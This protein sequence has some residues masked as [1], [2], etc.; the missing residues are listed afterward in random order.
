MPIDTRYR[1]YPATE[2]SA[3]K[4]S[5][6]QQLKQIEGAGQSHSINGR[7][8]AAA[9]FDRLHDGLANINAAIA[10]QAEQGNNGNAGYAS[11]YADFSGGWHG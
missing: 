9:Q 10:W 4:T 11:R 1:L 6:L 8:S 5:T 2:L 3:L 7:N